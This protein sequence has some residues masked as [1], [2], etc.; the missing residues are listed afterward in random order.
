VTPRP[1]DPWRALEEHEDVRLAFDPVARLLGGGFH[2]RRGGAA[3]IVLDPGLDREMATVVLTHELVHHERGGGVDRPG[4]PAGLATVAA[5]EER[6]VDRE[7]ARRLVPSDELERV[8]DEL[9]AGAGSADATAVGAHFGVPPA[10]A[11]LALEHLRLE[12]SRA[13]AAR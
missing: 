1:F 5:R 11:Q 3:L 4:R 6:A 9:V 12:R 13:E 8:V 10:V 2:V 7:V